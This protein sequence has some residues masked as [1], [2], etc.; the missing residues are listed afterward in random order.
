MEMIRVSTALFTQNHSQ[1][2]HLK[3]K[4]WQQL[5]S[6]SSSVPS[7]S[8]VNVISR[9]NAKSQTKVQSPQLSGQSSSIQSFDNPINFGLPSPFALSTTY[10]KG[11]T[12]NSLGFSP[13]IDPMF[14]RIGEGHHELITEEPELFEDP[15]YV[16]DQSLQQISSQFH[17]ALRLDSLEKCRTMKSFLLMYS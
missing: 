1:G 6:R 7:S 4:S 9:P 10:P 11:S 17:N 16:L 5:F 2:L 14:P 3:K 13:A 15:S 8:S 12:S